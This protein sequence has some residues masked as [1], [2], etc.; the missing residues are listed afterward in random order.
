VLLSARFG[1]RIADPGQRRQFLL[2]RRHPLPLLVNREALAQQRRARGT[3]LQPRQL[4]AR[5]CQLCRCRR[6]PLADR[7]VLDRGR[8]P[9]NRP[10][11]QIERALRKR[12][13]YVR[14]VKTKAN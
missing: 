2:Q 9:F 10:R 3:R 12:S 7:V 6:D 5:L 4:V 1:F 8:D 14:D 11:Q 13:S